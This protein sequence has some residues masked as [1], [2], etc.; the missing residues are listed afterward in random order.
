MKNVFFLFSCLILQGC[1]YNSY[2]TKLEE[3]IKRDVVSE[4][5]LS[6]IDLNDKKY[7]SAT[8][9]DELFI[10]N[11]YITGKNEII[12]V[13]AP[14]GKKFPQNSTWTGTY[15]Y[16]DGKSGDLI[17][18]TTPEYYKG[19]IG[20]VLD[21]NENLITDKPLVQL[22]G[23]KKG[24]RWALNKT[25]KFFIITNDNI[26]NWALRYG[27]RNE[28]KYVFEIINKLESNT[29][30]VL[31]TIYVTEKNFFNGFIIRNVLIKGISSNEYGVIQFE[32]TD[33][34]REKA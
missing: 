28:G 2:T 13:N 24:R 9:G 3:P 14:T 27:G 18:Y 17:V 30:D 16:N 5:Y 22:E 7:L 32:V 20:V 21:E 23:T 19:T 15:K 12:T 31:Q 4:Q 33:T 34:L 10:M 25:G 6:S 26:D 1:T 11:R 29:I 8:I